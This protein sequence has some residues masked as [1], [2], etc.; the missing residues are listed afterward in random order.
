MR[1][2]QPGLDFI[3]RLHPVEFR[4]IDGNDRL[5]L[6][7]IAQDLEQLLGVDY[8][9]SASAEMRTEPCRCAKPT[10]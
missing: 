10:L 9:L 5:D 8:N 3:T 1:D 2:I 4:L 6:G 7:F